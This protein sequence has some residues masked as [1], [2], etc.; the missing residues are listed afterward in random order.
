M[1]DCRRWATSL[2]TTMECLNRPECGP[3]FERRRLYQDC[4]DMAALSLFPLRHRSKLQEWTHRHASRKSRCAACK[5]AASPLAV[6][7]TIAWRW[8]SPRRK[9]FSYLR[10]KRYLTLFEVIGYPVSFIW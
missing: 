1:S 7:H 8:V 4:K 9:R 6:N 2:C 5:F 10:M 3:I